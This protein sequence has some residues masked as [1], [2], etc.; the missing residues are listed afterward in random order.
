LESLARPAGT[1]QG[2]IVRYRKIDPNEDWFVSLFHATPH[3]L[4]DRARDYR[5]IQPLGG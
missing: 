4:Y 5:V 1:G 3:R 2:G